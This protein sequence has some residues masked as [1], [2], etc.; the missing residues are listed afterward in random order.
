MRAFLAVTLDPETRARLGRVQHSLRDQ[1]EREAPRSRLSWA[2]PDTMHLTIAFFAAIETSA[3]ARLHEALA[4]SVSSLR[5]ARLPLTRLGAFPSLRE[6]RT[7]WAGPSD[8]WSR[9]SDGLAV[10]ELDSVVRSACAALSIE[11][12]D[13]ALRPHLTL[14]RV[15]DRERQV[16]L[17][18]AHV[19]SGHAIDGGAIDIQAVTFIE[20]QLGSNG[21][22]HK[23]HWSV[24]TAITQAPGAAGD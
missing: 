18:L 8:E 21:P 9:S 11:H 5:P 1:L 13:K 15:R 23:A 3:A 24:P 19:D 16:G 4:A 10:R 22:Q 2:R 14:A 17:A 6:P 12:D 7:I 20:S